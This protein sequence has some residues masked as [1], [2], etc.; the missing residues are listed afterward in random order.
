MTL[1]SQGVRVPRVRRRLRW[2]LQHGLVGVAVARAAR[3]GD[4]QARSVI[5][6]AHRANPYPL[7]E[8]VRA[9][10]PL[11]P[12]KLGHIT[13]THAVAS[14]VLRSDDFRAGTDADAMPPV[15][16]RL[17]AWSRDPLALGP[18]DPPSLLVVEPPDHTRYRRLVSRVFTA[19]AV[20]ALR[21]RVQTIA[22]DLLDEL[23][24]RR[25]VDLVEAYCSRLPV[26]VITEV[27]GVRPEDQDRVLDFG[28]RGAPS[29]DVGLTWA[30]FR[31]VDDAVRGFSHWLGDH[32]ARLR[33]DPGPDLLSQLVL[34]EDEGQ[35]LDE[36][37]LRS[38]AGL[39]LAAGFETT[40]NLLGSGTV[41]LLEHPEQR[42]RLR[43]DPS[44]WPTAVD[45]VLRY[46]SPV[47]LTA[48]FASR[49]TELAG[50]SLRRGGL[51]VTMLGGANRDPAVFADPARF[52]VGR[53]NARDH[54]SFSAGRHF[55][56]GASLARL[57]GE[58][59]LR[60]LFE[61]FPDLAAAPGRRRT[62]TRVLRGWESLPVS[63]GRVPVT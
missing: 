4:L 11:V 27:L 24:G 7:Y 13:A 59:G 49:D 60:S 29:L 6:P 61:R 52:D 53:P 22:D 35:R 39:V 25:D 30:Q 51:V 47:Q 43:A 9:R 42:E 33:R 17:V 8:E 63:T 16:Q 28:R 48:R 18:I 12:C 56:L 46:E 50:R 2:G 41:L 21:A 37:E 36:T 3:T 19:R 23:E 57:E 44:L 14:E 38:V 54:L 15:L 20:E 55:C 45:E 1:G 31:D 40:V 10:G 34:L 62:T 58:V 32:L 26:T 5:D